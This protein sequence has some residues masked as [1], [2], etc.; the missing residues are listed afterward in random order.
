M[1]FEKKCLIEP[2]DIIA[3]QY[4]CGNCRAAI[5]IPIE[6]LSP[7][8]VASIA[9]ASCRHCQTPSGFQMGTNETKSFLEFSRSLISIAAIMKG[10]NLKVR[11]NINCVD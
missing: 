7:D 8:S 10:H 1:T 9:V 6:K 5:I 2:D 4:E 3:V 11:L